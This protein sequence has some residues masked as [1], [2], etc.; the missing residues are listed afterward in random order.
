MSIVRL[1]AKDDRP[2][3]PTDLGDY[4]P[5]DYT[6]RRVRGKM[7][8]I[9]DP[10]IINKGH[11]LWHYMERSFERKAANLRDDQ[12]VVI[13]VHGFLFDIEKKIDAD[14]P[15]DND[16]P[17]GRIFHFY[18][19]NPDLERRHHSTSWPRRLGFEEHDQGANGLAIGFGYNSSPGFASSLI[20]HGKN[21]YS[22]AY[23]RAGKSAWVLVNILYF[24]SM[25]LPRARKVDIFC[26][27]LGS[28]VVL[29]AIALIADR[30][31]KEEVW[32]KL[33]EREETLIRVMEMLDRVIILGGAEYVF[34]T[35]LMMSR[36]QHVES[37]IGPKFYNF[38]S[39][40][41]DVLDRMG[42]NFGPAGFGNTN[43]IGHNGLGPQRSSDRWIDL[44]LDG[45]ALKRWMSKQQPSHEILGD[46][47]NE[48]W[49]HWIYYTFPPNMTLYE[50]IIRDRDRWTLG[51]LRSGE[52]PIP[53]GVGPWRNDTWQGGFGAD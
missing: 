40:E 24:L 43:V 1:S 21:I 4:E 15:Q 3:A 47:P 53:E 41:N 39:R 17:H 31:A 33:P 16:N 52:D 10:S 34:E 7:P 5:R 28:R 26:H 13:L 37:S 19:R 42:E 20:K 8:R 25:H 35:Q 45:G 38:A 36:I 44:Q 2:Y 12:P 46:N 50:S 22:R 6:R 23:E 14:D 49:D 48:P 32:K 30:L 29:R 11:D 18:V 27:S 51:G 9:V